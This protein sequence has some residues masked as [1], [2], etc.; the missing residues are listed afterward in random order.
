MSNGGQCDFGTM[1]WYCCLA[2]GH[3]GPH[4]SE[5]LA[6]ESQEVPA[7]PKLTCDHCGITVT[8][9]TSDIR[10][11]QVCLHCNVGAFRLVSALPATGSRCAN[12]GQ[13]TPPEQQFVG[14]AHDCSKATT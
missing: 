7:L 10:M 13:L 5:P 12:C 14:S 8:A 11:G 9:L 4:Q 1:D 3:D 6:A 2:D